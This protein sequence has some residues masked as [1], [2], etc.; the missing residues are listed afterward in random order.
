M[1]R[2]ETENLNI[3]IVPVGEIGTNCAVV[4]N[5]GTKEGFVVDPGAWADKLLEYIKE[6]EID[7][8][9]IL[10]THGHFD[11]IMAVNEL[12]DALKCDVYAGVNEEEIL[13]T[14][15]LNSSELVGNPYIVDTPENLLKDGDNIEMA[16]VSIKT[17][18][19]PGHTAGGVCFYVEDEKIIFAGDTVFMESVGRTDLPTGSGPTLIQSIK[20]KIIPLPDDVTIVPGHGPRTTVGHEKKHNPFFR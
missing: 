8:K 16:G 19:T 12:K 5:K 15:S 20:D 7:V 18:E 11:H 1:I 3:A 17:L 9:A 6:K 13:K 14:P 2:M 10:L 4:W